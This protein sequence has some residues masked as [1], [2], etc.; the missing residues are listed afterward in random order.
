MCLRRYSFS[1]MFLGMGKM[2]MMR[3]PSSSLMLH[4]S[5]MAAVFLFCF[6]RSESEFIKGHTAFI[7]IES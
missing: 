6:A 1:L 2:G 3:P 4:F 7:M 5:A